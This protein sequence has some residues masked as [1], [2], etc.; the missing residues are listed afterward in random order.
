VLC[1]LALDAQIPIIKSLWTSSFAMLTSGLALLLL[2]VL[3]LIMDRFGYVK[4]AM[5]IRVFGTN[6][7]LA[8]VF[9]WL[10][11]VFLD[12]TGLARIITAW[13]HS[14]ISDPYLMSFLF[15]FGVLV[16]CWL[17]VLPFYLK[18]IFLK[19]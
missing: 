8:Y 14:V 19:I 7:I 1:A 18:K 16:V 15:A 9:A 2:S 3:M 5:P 12:V 6:A 17:V 4:W 13:M 10:F 11:S